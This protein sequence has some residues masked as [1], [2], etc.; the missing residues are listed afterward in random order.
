MGIGIIFGGEENVKDGE[1]GTDAVLHHCRVC[2]CGFGCVDD[3][4]CTVG[5]ICHY[6]SQNDAEFSRG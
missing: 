3:L 6:F 2:S 4:G 5:V 1:G